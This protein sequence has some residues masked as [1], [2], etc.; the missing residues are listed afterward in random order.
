MPVLGIAA[1]RIR[2]ALSFRRRPRS[3][4]AVRRE[5][6]K[7]RPKFGPETLLAQRPAL[8]TRSLE[9]RMARLLMPDMGKLVQIPDFS[10][11]SVCG[12]YFL[13]CEGVVVYVGQA[14]CIRVRVATHIAEATKVFDSAAFIRCKPEN[15]NELERGYIEKLLPKYNHAIAHS[16]RVAGVVSDCGGKLMAGESRK[17]RLP[18]CNMRRTITMLA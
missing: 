3:R 7:P 8:T 11:L 4:N 2:V 9:D 17:V 13:M 6:S 5:N 16:L 12:I 1:R 15:L 14:K 10:N 18:R